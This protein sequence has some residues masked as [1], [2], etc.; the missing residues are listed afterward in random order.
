MPQEMKVRS[1]AEAR[2]LAARIGGTLKNEGGAVV[3]HPEDARRDGERAATEAITRIAEKMGE[4]LTRI[5]R[6]S[7]IQARA[8][9]AIAARSGVATSS[10]PSPAAPA[11]APGQGFYIE[12]VRNQKN[13]LIE[14]LIVKPL[15]E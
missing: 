6:T 8:M 4:A 2:A 14:G 1:V 12:I 9:V 15:K 7:D 13:D 11:R 5:E 10:A 3:H